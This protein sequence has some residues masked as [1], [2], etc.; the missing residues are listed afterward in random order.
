MVS[1]QLSF[2]TKVLIHP[3]IVPPHKLLLTEGPCLTQSDL[4]LEPWSVDMVRGLSPGQLCRTAQLQS[5]P[6]DGP[7][8]L[9]CDHIRVQLLLLNSTFAIPSQVPYPKILPIRHLE[10]KRPFQNLFP[11]GSHF[12]EL[13]PE[14]ECSKEADHM[15]VWNWILR[16]LA[17]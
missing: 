2:R 8:G 14:I 5:S 9:D 11:R 16:W 6:W 4:P 3:G 17:G 13:G 15:G 7:E 12:R 1:A 10:F